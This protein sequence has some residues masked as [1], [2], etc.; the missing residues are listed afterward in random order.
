MGMRFFFELKELP[1]FTLTK[2]QAVN[3]SDLNNVVRNN[4]VFLKQ[5]HSLGLVSGLSF[6][7]FYSL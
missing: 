1:D 7:L 3:I 4:A 5:L 6:H 2:Y